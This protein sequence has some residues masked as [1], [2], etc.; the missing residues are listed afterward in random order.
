MRWLR[1]V[2]RCLF[3]DELSLS[4]GT[5]AASHPQLATKKGGVKE[6]RFYGGTRSRSP[7][8]GGRQRSLAAAVHVRV[9]RRSGASTLG[10]DDARCEKEE[11]AACLER[12]RRTEHEQLV[13]PAQAGHGIR[14]T[15]EWK[16]PAN[17]HHIVNGTQTKQAVLQHGERRPTGTD[18]LN[19][20][21]SRPA[22]C[23]SFCVLPSGFTRRQTF[24]VS[25]VL[26]LFSLRIS[27]LKFYFRFFCFIPA[28]PLL[29][30]FCFCCSLLPNFVLSGDSTTVPPLLICSSFPFFPQRAF[31]FLF[32]L[33]VCVCV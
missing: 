23:S 2:A 19:C 14:G 11:P 32:L 9:R 25:L 22:S 31:L 6:S 30:E 27:K 26:V 1:G 24:A 15:H 33:S 8:L 16:G 18:G 21:S 17:N 10:R 29:S 13:K 5:S 20:S 7:P 4:A 12:L 28:P 3:A